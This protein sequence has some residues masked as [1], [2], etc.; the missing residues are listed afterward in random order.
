VHG[1]APCATAVA[2]NLE[3]CW[4]FLLP[5]SAAQCTAYRQMLSRKTSITE[6]KAGT[7]QCKQQLSRAQLK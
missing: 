7:W 2:M 5:T 1:G 6:D 3:K 4:R